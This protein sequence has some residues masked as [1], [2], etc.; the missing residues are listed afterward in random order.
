MRAKLA[1]ELTRCA[2]NS[3]PSLIVED[4]LTKKGGTMNWSKLRSIIQESVDRAK[5]GRVE[6]I[7]I[8]IQ[9]GP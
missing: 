1:I 5:Q 3:I 2:D 4:D 6:Q 8:T 7:T 9:G